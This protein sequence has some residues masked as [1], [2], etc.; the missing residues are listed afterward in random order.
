MSKIIY[1]IRK[2]IIEKNISTLMNDSLGVVLEFNKFDEVTKMCEI[3]NA[4]S[5]NNCRYEIQ[6][7]NGK[8]L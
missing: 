1:Q 7:V 6:V 2:T 5:D 3:M 4:N 8:K